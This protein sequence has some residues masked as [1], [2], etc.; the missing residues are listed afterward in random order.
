MR[1][2]KEAKARLTPGTRLLCIE[3]TYRPEL[4]G[5]TRVVVK[6]GATVWQWRHEDDAAISYSDLPA[7]IRVLDPDTFSVPI[8]TKSEHRVTLRFL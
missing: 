5:R 8:R 1:T 6:A 2:A 7:G 3:N 4:N